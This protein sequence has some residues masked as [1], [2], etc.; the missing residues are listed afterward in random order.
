MSAHKIKS[1]KRERKETKSQK[2]LKLL[3]LN[4]G[5]SD[6]PFFKQK[7]E[8]VCK[9][10]VNYKGRLAR[11]QLFTQCLIKLLKISSLPSYPRRRRKR[12]EQTERSIDK[13]MIKQYL[14]QNFTEKYHRLARK[15]RGATPI[16][17]T[18]T[19]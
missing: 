5:G 13:V 17:T 8:E 6:S 16:K 2:Q 7:R 3:G 12:N 14:M 10:C 1:Q 9:G 19:L 11:K 4:K 15:L 18:L